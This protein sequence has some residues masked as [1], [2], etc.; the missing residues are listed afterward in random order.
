MI[1]HKSREAKNAGPGTWSSISDYHDN[2]HWL[3]AKTDDCFLFACKLI[4]LE[5][6][7]PL[8]GRI[9]L[10]FRSP[11]ELGSQTWRTRL[12]TSYEAHKPY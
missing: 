6:K 3:P 4:N 11:I 9:N 5:R 7:R 10:D 2:V 1:V 8:K 12:I